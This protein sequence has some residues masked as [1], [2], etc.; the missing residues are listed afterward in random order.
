MIKGQLVGLRAIEKDDLALLRDWRNLTSLRRNFREFRELNMA[1]QEAWFAKLNSSQTDFMFII[2]RLTDSKPIGACGLLS[3][4]W[5]IRS[6]DFSFY[7][8]EDQAYIDQLG[9]ANDAVN[10]LINYGFH[11]LNLNKIWME[12]YEFDKAKMDFFCSVGFEKRGS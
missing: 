12:L 5:I 6:A 2:E 4:H 8:G 11:N 1:N 10:L 7:I 3:I 9:F